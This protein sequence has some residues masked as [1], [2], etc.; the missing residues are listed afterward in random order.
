MVEAQGETLL[1]LA[2]LLHSLSEYGQPASVCVCVCVRARAGGVLFVL[3]CRL[4][5]PSGDKKKYLGSSHCST[6]G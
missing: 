4:L 1:S 6:V 5:G 2:S 3:K